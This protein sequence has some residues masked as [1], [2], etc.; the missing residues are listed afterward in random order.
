MSRL[1]T[2]GLLVRAI[3]MIL[4]PTAGETV[5]AQA[6]HGEVANDGYFLNAREITSN[7]PATSQAF[8][9][10]I[11]EGAAIAAA[12][13]NFF[14]S[15][16]EASRLFSLQQGNLLS[17]RV[18]L[19]L[20]Q[21]PPF[22]A[23]TRANWCSASPAPVGQN[24]KRYRYD[25]RAP[26]NHQRYPRRD[27]PPPSGGGGG[28]DGDLYCPRHQRTGADLLRGAGS[29]AKRIALASAILHEG[30]HCEDDR[31]ADPPSDPPPVPDPAERDRACA[32]IE[33]YTLQIEFILIAMLVREGQLTPED[34]KA[35][36]AYLAYLSA[37]LQEVEDIKMENGG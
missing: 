24:D 29:M 8:S 3:L 7:H 4:L 30:A 31:T 34:V 36:G 17:K 6:R 32:E 14:A 22:F 9:A 25:P 23:M 19:G 11:E 35:L 27:F 26:G 20:A 18:W 1:M 2:W 10:A 12:S 37:L 13:G 16:D 28:G 5:A 33:A 21:V 15:A